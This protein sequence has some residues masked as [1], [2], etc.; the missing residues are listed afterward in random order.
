M[1]KAR[2]L[3]KTLLAEIS[4]FIVFHKTSYAR[5][6]IDT[7]LYPFADPNRTLGQY[8][9]ALLKASILGAAVIAF[10]LF[11]GGGMTMISSSGDPQRQ[12]QGKTAITAGV[13]G[14]VLVVSAFWIIEL[15]EILTGLE[16]TNPPL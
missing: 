11:L 5:T 6:I 10:L 15:I 13:L 16:L 12:Q 8:V 9:S 4:L 1:K 14:L 7:N 2:F 3:I